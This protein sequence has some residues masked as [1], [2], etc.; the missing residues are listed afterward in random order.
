MKQTK[1]LISW[2]IALCMLCAA[3]PIS[4]SAADGEISTAAELKN[5]FETG[6]TFTLTA[7]IAVEEPLV[8]A[9]KNTLTLRGNDKTI[10]AAVTGL[11]EL[12]VVNS[13]ATVIDNLIK[14]SGALTLENLTVFGGKG[15]CIHNSG[16]LTMT[17]VSVERAHLTSGYGAGLYNIST[18]KAVLTSC[19]IRRN[20]CDSAGGGFYNSGILILENT[21][22]VENR[23]F[24]S[25]NGGGGG[26]NRGTL[27]MNNCTVSNNQSSEIGGGIN[28]YGGTAYIM[29]STFTGNVTTAATAY[30]GGAIGINGGKVYAANSAFAYNF[31]G[32]VLNDI[33]IYSLSEKNVN[34]YNCAYG[35]I[36]KSSSSSDPVTTNCQTLSD[37]DTAATVFNGS[38][39]SGIIDKEGI[40][41]T[42]NTFELPLIT[43]PDGASTY[44]VYLNA[45]SP[46]KTGG[47]D[48]YYKRDGFTVSMSYKNGGNLDGFSTLPKAIDEDK[49]TEYADGTGRSSGVIGSASDKTAEYY[50]VKVNPAKGG[51]VIGGSAQG[52]TYVKGSDIKITAVPNTGYTFGGWLKDDEITPS[53]TAPEYTISSI[54]SN[55]TLTPV[56]N[57]AAYKITF[58]TNGGTISGSV[59]TGYNTG[60]TVSLPTAAN[61]TKS[62]YTFDGWYDNEELSGD[63]VT[64]ISDTDTGDKEY[65][66]KWTAVPVPTPTPSSTSSHRGSSYLTIKFNTNGGSAVESQRV[67][68][69]G[70]LGTVKDPVKD[71]FSFG[72]WYTDREL[73]KPF[74]LTEKITASVTVYAKWLE[75]KSAETETDNKII[76]T[77]GKKEASVFGKTKINDVAPVISAD[78]TMLPARFVAE[79]LGAKVLWDEQNQLVTITGKN[80]KTDED[81]T[82]LITIGADSA[83]VNNKEIKLD[84]SAFIENDRTYTPLRFISENLGANVEW[85]E[86]DKQVLITK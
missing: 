12:G 19:N 34:L 20:G 29:N 70:R 81:T 33:G 43:K 25:G 26:E 38:R 78:R 41:D 44:G 35:K 36:N 18:A 49:V 32:G 30:Y 77:I 24:G 39:S 17:S 68:R 3:L 56:F 79:N 64:A 62:G 9:A 6:G 40:E 13:D 8:L 21:S 69:N 23:N 55:I 66:A 16:E 86:S 58:N 52:N 53:N 71:G 22:I 85:N 51:T 42:E 48:T 65:W 76:L 83:M 45:A 37:T 84:S 54:D 73:T 1:K 63:A 5:A 27:Y 72:G 57:A 74:D 50:T 75:T 4:V 46:L 11:N 14:N 31:A 59:P 60:G 61:I 2:F 10:S 15:E 82:I 47:T 80:L 7:D 28:N 67:K